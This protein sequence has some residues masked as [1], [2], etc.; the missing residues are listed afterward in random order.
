M[1]IL[2]TGATGFIGQHLTPTLLAQNH[3]VA[4]LVR[5]SYA[6]GK[7][8]PPR[9]GRLRSHFQL[10]YA[11]LRNFPLTVRAVQEVQ[12]QAV[13]HLAAAGP[14]DPFLAVEV[15]LRHNVN[16]VINLLRACFEKSGGVERVI[17]ARTPG[18]KSSMNVYAA[19]KA[20]AWSFCQMYAHTR[21]WPIEGAM[22]FQAF[23]PGQPE[24]ALIP[25]ALAAAQAGDDFPMTSGEQRKDWIY[26]TD[27][28]AGL[29]R[30]AGVGL[31]AGI[32]VDLGTGHGTRTRDVVQQLYDLVGCGGRPRPGMLPDRPG[33]DITQVADSQRTQALLAW[34]PVYTL[35]QGLSQLLTETG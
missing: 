24:S 12:P 21:G 19:S 9:L 4:L 35:S 23:G 2:V 18:E 3:E 29:A 22:I 5:D 28:A 10:V 6:A 17:V 7:L 8:L 11:D 25:A 13:V 31:D 30:L 33:E 27:V 14:N 26:V 1:K 15:A 20:A 16:G 34:Q 32:T